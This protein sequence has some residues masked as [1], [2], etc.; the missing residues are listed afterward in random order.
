MT[1]PSARLT[2]VTFVLALLPRLDGTLSS[3]INPAGEPR[4]P[5]STVSVPFIPA[6][7]WPPTGQ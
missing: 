6:S 2:A 5:Y 4:A 1:F 7:S 3:A